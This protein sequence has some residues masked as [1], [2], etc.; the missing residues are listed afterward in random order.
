MASQLKII[1]N[2]ISGSGRAM[3]FLER[4]KDALA[5]AAIEY[6]VA[7]TQKA[8]DAI[9][10]AQ[11]HPDTT[12][13]LCLGGDGTLNEVIN[14][15]VANPRFDAASRPVL[16][17]IPFGSGNVIAKELKLKRSVRQFIHLFRDNLTNQLDLGCIYLPK[18]NI[19]RYFIS[20]AGIG[21][22]AEVARKYHLSRKDGSRLQAHLFS[23]FPIALKHLFSYRAPKIT[24]LA[25]G[26]A[27]GT[28]RQKRDKPLTEDASFV[29]VANV[30]SYGGPFVL[31]N[32]AIHN[33]GLLDACWFSGRSSLS[34]L[35]YYTLALLGNLPEWPFGQAGG[36]LTSAGHQRISKV[37]ITSTQPEGTASSEPV[38]L[39]V[40][41]DFCGCLPAEIEV[42]P[43]AIRIFSPIA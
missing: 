6:E 33:D 22:D 4:L 41:G 23:Y 15:L 29:Q 26:D 16:G 36:S 9:S 30:R 2:P 28:S 35:Y 19:R 42:A 37:T 21:F 20:M 10:L 39:Q 25:G 14:G 34:I 8:G 43:K 18:E 27:S 3:R 31:V 40:D 1:V 7:P 32:Q 5:K 24:I 11:A 38:A 12:P 17:F 13:I